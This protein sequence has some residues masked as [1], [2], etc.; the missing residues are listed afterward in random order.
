MDDIEDFLKRAAQR[1]QAK[2]SQSSPAPPPAPRPEYSDSRTERRPRNVPSD[3]TPIQATL[4]DEAT[5]PLNEHLQQIERQRIRVLVQAAKR[6]AGGTVKPVS[7][8]E[9]SVPTVT[10]PTPTA[11]VDRNA[12]PATMMIRPVTITGDDAGFTAMDRL[13]TMLRQPEGMLQAVLLQEIL[14]RPT[15][16]W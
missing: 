4:V 2:A 11:Q 10:A 16:R 8:A 3:D 5:E 13:V 14:R 1:R 15:E 9:D 12:M 6:R 7:M